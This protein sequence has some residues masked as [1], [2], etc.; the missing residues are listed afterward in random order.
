ML[1]TAQ[2]LPLSRTFDTGLPPD[3]FPNQAASLLPGLLATTRT[4]L[5]PASD[6]ELTITGH[7][8]KA[9]RNLLVARTIEARVRWLSCR[10]LSHTP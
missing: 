9:T 6:D 2:S 5:T 3:P 1:R 8:H 10:A 7:L 4:G